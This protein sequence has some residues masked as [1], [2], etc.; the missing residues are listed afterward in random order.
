[1][2]RNVM[3][4]LFFLGVAPVAY[5]QPKDAERLETYLTFA[6]VYAEGC[7]WMDD[8]LRKTCARIGPHLSA[9]NSKMCV[10]PARPYSE[11]IA[12]SYPALKEHF[13]TQ[14]K[15]MEPKLG[16][17]RSSTQKSLEQQFA[18]VVAGKVSMLDLESLSRELGDRCVSIETEWLPSSRWPK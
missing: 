18:Q 16:K 4:I 17:V 7:T 9:P 11:R 10:L 14:I 6:I 15:A 8:L 12:K 3:L 5:A 1:M 2:R 13:A